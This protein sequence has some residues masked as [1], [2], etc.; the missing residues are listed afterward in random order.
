[1]QPS[2]GGIKGTVIMVPLKV[3]SLTT[4]RVMVIST[5]VPCGSRSLKAV[6]LGMLWPKPFT[7]ASSTILSI[8]S[9]DEWREESKLGSS[10]C[11]LRLSS[12]F[13]ALRFAMPGFR[14]RP[15][16]SV[17]FRF[18]LSKSVQCEPALILLCV[19]LKYGQLSRSPC[20]KMFL[21]YMWIQ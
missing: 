17:S 21:L 3:C 19:T 8:G 6:T 5:S 2:K 18:F 12:T 1:M 16:S 15:F 13:A 10:G 7:A 20:P 11:F 4:F 14:L 9:V